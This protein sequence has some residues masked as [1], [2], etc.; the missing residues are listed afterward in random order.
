MNYVISKYFELKS[1]LKNLDY[2]LN[3]YEG[4]GD[5]FDNEIQLTNQEI[6][7]L[8]DE[9][10]K[11]NNCLDEINNR[12]YN[13]S[14]NLISVINS[15]LSQFDLAKKKGLFPTLGQGLIIPGYIFWK[16]LDDLK[17][18]LISE[19]SS[20]PK[21]WLHIGNDI[22]DTEGFESLLK[23]LIIELSNSKLETFKQIIEFFEN[24]SEKFKLEYNIVY[25]AKYYPS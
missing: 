17:H 1:D 3:L 25:K 9:L 21:T 6:I 15:F 24:T 5:K 4:Y 2:K 19:G 14:N 22:W 13:V 7:S 23:S 18:T 11:L 12:T 16:I 8:Q 10:S 20:H